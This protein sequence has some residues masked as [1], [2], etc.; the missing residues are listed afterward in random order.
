MPEGK[1][2]LLKTG[3]KHG[4][5]VT[6]LGLSSKTMLYVKTSF[7]HFCLDW[8]RPVLPD[9]QTKNSNLGKFCKALQWKMLVFF[10]SILYIL[11]ILRPNGILPISSFGTFG[12]H[13]VYFFPLFGML[14]Q[15]NLATLTSASFFGDQQ[16]R[17][18]QQKYLSDCCCTMCAV[19]PD[20]LSNKS[21]KG[22]LTK[23]QFFSQNFRQD[24]RQV[25]RPSAEIADKLMLYFTK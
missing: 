20:V 10:M 17:F 21:K 4:T 18:H 13:S 5:Y 3:L 19:W 1:L 6:V 14:C 8:R 22:S 7:L 23:A 11:S 16:W 2:M 12:G 25:C 15:K 9:F 24:S